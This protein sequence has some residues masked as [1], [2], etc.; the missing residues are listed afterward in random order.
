VYAAMFIDKASY[1]ALVF[2]SKIWHD[3]QEWRWIFVRP[4]KKGHPYIE[5]PLFDDSGNQCIAAICTG[6]NCDYLR[7][8]VPLQWLLAQTG[9]TIPIPETQ[10][11]VS[12]PGFMP[13]VLQRPN[14]P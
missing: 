9:Q 14:L 5:L 4:D 8:T 2:K 11:R 10:H 3:E 7:S 13:P 6:P 12:I 1:L